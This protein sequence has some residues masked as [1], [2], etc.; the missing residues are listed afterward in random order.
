[1]NV[2]CK[3]LPTE[4][5]VCGQR[6]SFDLSCK[7]KSGEDYSLKFDLREA[8]KPESSVCKSVR[9][10]EECKLVKHDP[11]FFDRL[12]HDSNVLK[13]SLKPDW[14]KWKEEEESQSPQDEQYESSRIK[15]LSAP[16]IDEMVQKGAVV[17]ADIYFPWCSHCG[18]IRKAFMAAAKELSS[19]KHVFAWVDARE[20]HAAA[21]R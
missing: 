20:D 13:Q 14:S 16:E 17:I 4:R 3:I 11:H 1:L 5:I 15:Q 19:E 21:T 7:K 8:I 18:Y 10:E 9:G 2:I 6:Y 12:T